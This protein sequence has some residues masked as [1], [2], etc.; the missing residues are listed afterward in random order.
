MWRNSY[1]GCRACLLKAQRNALTKQHLCVCKAVLSEVKL[2]VGM[3][4]REPWGLDSRR[5]PILLQ[6]LLWGEG[7]PGPGWHHRYLNTSAPAW[8]WIIHQATPCCPSSPCCHNSF[9]SRKTGRW[10]RRETRKV[11]ERVEGR[12]LKRWDW[13]LTFK[14]LRMNYLYRYRD[15][16]PYIPIW[17]DIWR[18]ISI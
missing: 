16:S 6:R 15:M 17:M 3:R 1:V 18:H 5:V 10:K 7:S 2:E 12:G 9:P 11:R 8:L 13:R 4:G 14:T